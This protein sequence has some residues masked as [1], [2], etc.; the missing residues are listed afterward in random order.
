[1]YMYIDDQFKCN[2]ILFCCLTF[3]SVVTQARCTLA[4]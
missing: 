2:I 1:M 4:S 3:T